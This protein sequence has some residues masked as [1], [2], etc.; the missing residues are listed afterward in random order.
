MFLKYLGLTFIVF[1]VVS[2]LMAVG[3]IFRKKALK[4]SCGGLSSFMGNK[5]KC[6]FCDKKKEDCDKEKDKPLY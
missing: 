6:F 5:I 4:G 3:Y 2:L 1:L